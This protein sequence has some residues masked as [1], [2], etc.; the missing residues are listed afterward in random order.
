M[1]VKCFD[2]H[3]IYCDASYGP[4]FGRGFD[5]H[6]KKNS[7]TT[8]SSFSYLC[9]SYNYIP[10]NEPNEHSLFLAGSSNF[11][12]SEIEVFYVNKFKK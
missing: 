8:V 4:T 1:P 5:L 11:K 3:Y 2:T 9:Q 6:I 12:T 10:I 7:N